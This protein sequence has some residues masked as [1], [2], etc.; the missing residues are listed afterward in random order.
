MLTNWT[1]GD[2]AKRDGRYYIVVNTNCTWPKHEN[3]NIT[4]SVD[5]GWT[6]HWDRDGLTYVP[7][8]QRILTAAV[9]E[10]DEK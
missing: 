1:V 4:A 10:G 5:S 7:E 2:W 6:F 3:C 9:D 8:G